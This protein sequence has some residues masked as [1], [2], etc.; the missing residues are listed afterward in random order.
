MPST[1]GAR[2]GEQLRARREAVRPRLTQA[3]LAER[4]GLS[5]NYLSA[6]ERGQKLPSIETL[7]A[8][9]RALGVEPGDL[10]GTSQRDPWVEQVA[11]VAEG[12]PRSLRSIAL[13]VLRAVAVPKT[14]GR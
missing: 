11:V 9:A 10:L 14:R 7:A 6:L 13:A 1:V 12:V 5:E 8:L 4:V 3:K 2:L